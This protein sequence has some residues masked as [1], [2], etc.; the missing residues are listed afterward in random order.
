MKRC[1]PDK[2]RTHE[3]NDR[4]AR[5]LVRKLTAQ[6]RSLIRAI[7]ESVFELEEFVPMN[8]FGETDEWVASAVARLKKT[9]KKN[10]PKPAL[11]KK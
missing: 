3:I 7:R 2:A 8:R 9:V 6:K 10:S 1:A 5:I 4:L 11:W